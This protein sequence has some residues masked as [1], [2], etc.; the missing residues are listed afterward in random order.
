MLSKLQLLGK[1]PKQYHAKYMHFSIIQLV[2]NHYTVVLY[3][4]ISRLY[5]Y[6]I[7]A[8]YLS[9]CRVIF[10]VGYRNREPGLN[11]F[12]NISTMQ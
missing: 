1:N 2:P 12:N 8:V 10:F 4:P 7:S 9:N 6:K 5:I 11:I 3:E